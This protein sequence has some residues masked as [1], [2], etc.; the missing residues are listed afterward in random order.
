MK[1]KNQK[2][3]KK[4]NNE[5]KKSQ[6]LSFIY[7]FSTVASKYSESQNIQRF[8]SS[9]FRD[10]VRRGRDINITILVD[11]ITMILFSICRNC[12]TR[13]FQVGI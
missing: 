11:G 3:L 4:S 2:R 6:Y 10:I 5:D 13:L 1:K 9:E 12:L 8:Q 7:N